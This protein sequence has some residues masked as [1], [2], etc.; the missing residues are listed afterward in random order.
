M[1]R[2]KKVRF[3]AEN[4]AVAAIYFVLTVIL[5][6]YS[7]MG[8]QFRISEMLV[9]L[10]FWRPD[11]VLGVTL[12]C[13]LANTLSSLGPWDMLFGTLA[14]LVS[15]LGVAYLSPRLWFACL[16]PIAVNAFAVGAELYFLLGLDY[17]MQ[18]GLVCLG[19]STVIIVS[20][21][22]W[23]ILIRNKGFRHFLEPTR[24]QEIL[25]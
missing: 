13:F 20:Y 15:A 12:G 5:A 22:L 10:C 19:E 18:T 16:Y 23:I 4:A 21:I 25:C 11:F 3:I 2:D 17:W 24:H 9:L 1:T 7:Y 14:T 6:P 8:I